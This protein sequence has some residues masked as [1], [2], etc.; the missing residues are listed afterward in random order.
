MAPVRFRSL[1]PYLAV[2]FPLAGLLTAVVAVLGGSPW[3]EAGAV[4]VP[5]AV[6]FAFLALGAGY[7]CRVLPL[8][9]TTAGRTALSHG[10]TALVASSLWVG[11]ARLLAVGLD[12][13]D[14]F[15]GVAG[16]VAGLAG[17]LM[18][19]GV[20]IYLLAV[21]V[22]YLATAR[23]ESRLA[24]QRLLEAE[25]AAREAELR[26]LKAQ[27]DPHFLFNSLNS[28]NALVGRDPEAARQV[29]AGLGDL[30]RLNLQNGRKRWIA[31]DDELEMVRMYLDLEKVRL[32]S[33]L[34][35]TEQV[36]PTALT[37]RV[38]PLV[39][40][41]LVENALKHGIGSMIA[42]GLVTL[43][44]RVT[45]DR[46]MLTVTNPMD[47][48]SPA[49]PGTGT[50]LQNLRRRLMALYGNEAQLKA[51]GDR[52]TYSAMVTLPADGDKDD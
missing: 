9:R 34:Q 8:S 25:L 45:G 50:G 33:R 14:L 6:L 52:E 37:R 16:R 42:G 4:A 51:G 38:P 11:L 19:L 49:R 35:V 22:H 47:P 44:G 30:M 31:L 32:G 2:L 41:P 24:E 39:L 15:P 5:M 27:I 26:A 18:I 48:D 29:C 40:Q 36:E 1:G 12:R 7:S 13:A 10:I 43:S 20:L 46:L 17:S 3:P 23:E 21:A 28:I